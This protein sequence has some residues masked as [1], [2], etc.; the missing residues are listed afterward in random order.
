M[1]SN[2]YMVDLSDAHALVTG[3]G[4]G[5]GEQV[6]RALSSAGACVS[7]MGRTRT[8]LASVAQSLDH[9][10]QIAVADVTDRS[11]VAVAI[12]QLVNQGGPID[13]LVNNA[14]NAVSESFAGGEPDRWDEMIDVNLNGIF[15]TT[16][17]V[18]P[19]MKKLASGRIVTIASTAGLKGYPYVVG[20]CAAKHGAIGFTRALAVELAGSGITVNAV[21]PGFTETPM[22]S[23]S[24]DTIVRKTG[25]NRDETR[26]D[27]TRMNPQ[28]R[29]IQPSEVADCVM[30]LCSSAASSVNGQALPVDGGETAL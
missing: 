19:E 21:C 26:A 20:Y 4:S 27:L 13:I 16:R 29:L 17:C 10:S 11:G 24:I 25:R 2:K 1:T 18:L 9:K 14:G 28:G 3:A 6:A 12:E 5:I 23:R 8:K 7:L 22:L 30:W 15:N